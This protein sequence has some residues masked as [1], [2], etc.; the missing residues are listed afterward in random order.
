VDL[1]PLDSRHHPHDG[2]PCPEDDHP[3]G[4][5]DERGH[6]QNEVG[7]VGPVTEQR[8]HGQDEQRGQRRQDEQQTA[9]FAE[10]RV[11]VG[12]SQGAG[13]LIEHGGAA[14]ADRLAVQVAAQVVGQFLRGRVA[15]RRLLLEAL[16]AD[17]LQVARHRR[18][19]PRGRGRVVLVDL[20]ERLQDRRAQERRPA[21]EALV[22]D[23]AQR[24]DVTRR[25]DVRLA[26]CLFGGHVTGCAQDGPG[27]GQA[28]I[29][30]PLGEA[31]VG[32]LG[33]AVAGEQHV[34]GL[35]ITMDDA[36]LVG[37]LDRLSDALDQLG[38]PPRRQGAVAEGVGQAAAGDQ[39]Q[40]QERLPAGLAGLVDLDDVR[41]LERG[42]GL[43]LDPEPRPLRRAGA[44][45]QDHLQSHRPPQPSLP[46]LVDDAHAAVADDLD[47][48]VAVD[49][50]QGLRGLGRCGGLQHGPDAQPPV[51]AAA[52]LLLHGGVVG[53]E[54]LG[55]QGVAL[56]P[57][58]LPLHQQVE[59][60]VLV[61]RDQRLAGLAAHA[62]PAR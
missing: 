39:L 56:L 46:G 54:G 36:A 43:G 34:G 30:G 58:L 49:L 57:P 18:V 44:G 12:A 41:V 16:Q 14:G 31:E 13:E 53:A 45:P 17:D 9:P 27:G 29:V 55:R 32:D 48:L 5:H 47:D 38:R 35:E 28:G 3:Y 2:P 50:G 42:D 25:P 23:G 40:R 51:D 20:A 37:V 15:A 6:Q 26:L 60:L 8:H 11:Q 22:E 4:Q 24:P 10:A 62:H 59:E 21:G 33:R 19:E 52:K 7:V 1:P 61:Q